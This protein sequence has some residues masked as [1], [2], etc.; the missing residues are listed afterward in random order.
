MSD[1][2]VPLTDIAMPEEDVQAVLACLESGWLTM[3]PRTKAFEQALAEYVNCP[4]AATVSSG[5]AALHL[6][7]LAAGIGAGDEVIVPAFTFVASA[8]AVRYVGA[9]PVL[10]DVLDSRHFNLD[11]EDVARRITPRTRA[12]VAVHFCGY[13]AE[14]LALR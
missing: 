11:P 12:V 7:C 2:R 1:W 6:S 10:C 4:H 14:V 8:S 5:T 9:E 3:G 13:P